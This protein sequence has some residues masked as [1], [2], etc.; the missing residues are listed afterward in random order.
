LNVRINDITKEIEATNKKS[1]SY[2]KKL[3]KERN[4]SSSIQRKRK[5]SVRML[6]LSMLSFCIPRKK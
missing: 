2:K 6:P 1:L 3:M 4:N 5:N